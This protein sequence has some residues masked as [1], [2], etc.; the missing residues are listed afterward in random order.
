M[1]MRSLRLIL[2][3]FYN[4]RCLAFGLAPSPTNMMQ[5]TPPVN[6]ISP[7]SSQPSL[8][9]TECYYKPG[10]CRNEPG[11]P[12]RHLGTPLASSPQSNNL[13]ENMNA[14]QPSN[15][16]TRTLAQ[17]HEELKYLNLDVMNK[18]LRSHEPSLVS[19]SKSLSLKDA[20]ENLKEKV[21]LRT[22]YQVV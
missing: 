5:A 14:N 3:I 15:S 22:E 6:S 4:Y 17:Q 10:T 7:N 16:L 11:S 13:L 2:L 19:P 12:V 8:F 1:N 9:C 20:T 18:S 21:N